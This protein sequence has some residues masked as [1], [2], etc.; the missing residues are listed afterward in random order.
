VEDDSQNRWRQ[1]KEAYGTRKNIKKR[2]RRASDVTRRHARRFL[3]KRWNSA[4]D[5]RRLI[6]IWILAVAVL[7]GATGLQLYWYQQAYRTQAAANNGTYAEAV[8]GPVGTLNPLFVSSRAEEDAARLLFSSLF[9]YDSTGH[10]SGDLAS[11]MSVDKSGTEYT[12]KLRHDAHWHD[13]YQLTANDVVFT[14]GLLRN[15]AVR[16]TNH[17]DW[18]GISVKATDDYTVVF[19]LPVVIAAFPNALTFS[20]LPQHI[21]KNVTPNDIRENQYSNAPIG[22]GPFGFRLLQDVDTSGGMRVIHLERN[23]N[24]YGGKSKIEFLQI[25]AYKNRD[26]IIKALSTGEVNAASDLSSADL[27]QV[28]GSRYIVR[29]TPIKSGVYALLNTTQ[30]VLKDVAIRRALQAGTDTAA[31]RKQLGFNA[32]NLYLPFVNDQLS[33][34]A[35]VQPRF[36]AALANQLLDQAGWT[37]KNGVRSK[38]NVPLVLS[39]VTIKDGDYERI[40]ESLA[41]QWRALGIQVSTKVIDLEDATQNALQDTLQTRNYDVLIYQLSIGADPDVYAYWHSSQANALGFNLSNYS[42]ALADDT[43][44][45]ARTRLEPAL[46]NA[47]YLT[48]ARQWLLD[49]PAIG[50]YQSVYHYVYSNKDTTYSDKAVLVTPT[51]RYGDILYWSVGNHSVY[52]TP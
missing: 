44:S 37:L 23:S 12:V 25:N 2:V 6:V 31:A 19:K 34:T 36:D 9:Q 41:G 50:L 43:L 14:V 33:G 47:K 46:R 3:I 15:S 16:S 48:F 32:T 42:S 18:S 4:R 5:A 27:G 21:L 8:L 11:N 35:P 49:A 10:L 29:T 24:Y 20:V 30:G 26:Q 51:D 39:V 40:L 22:S 13:G 28:D 38:D 7:I 52:K 45:S 17:E 1:A